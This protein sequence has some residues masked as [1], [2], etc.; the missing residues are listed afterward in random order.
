MCR[1][2]RPAPSFPWNHFSLECSSVLPLACG[3]R[4][5]AKTLSD[6]DP[7]P[8]PSPGLAPHLLGL[9]LILIALVAAGLLRVVDL[10]AGQ[11]EVVGVPFL[12]ETEAGPVNGGLLPPGPPC[13]ARPGPHMVHGVL[14]VEDAILDGV[15]DIIL[16]VHHRR[17]HLFVGAALRQLLVLRGQAGMWQR[18]PSRTA[19][20]SSPR[21]RPP[22]GAVAWEGARKC[23]APTVTLMRIFLLSWLG[24]G[25]PSAAMS[26]GLVR[27]V[28]PSTFLKYCAIFL[29]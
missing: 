16:G 20:T 12:G 6:S 29:C 25:S 27:S 23:G 21:L 2:S 13:S 8:A 7:S 4:A 14:Q 17:R 24:E 5:T 19:P 10:A 22:A 1:P 11:N 28:S 15:A 9:L 18:Q 26:T 3:G